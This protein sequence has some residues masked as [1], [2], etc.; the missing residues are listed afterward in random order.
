MQHNDLHVLQIYCKIDDFCQVY[1]TDF[2]EKNDSFFKK[3]M[4]L[5][6]YPF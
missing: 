3:E 5:Q 2:K 4:I 1:F 6:A